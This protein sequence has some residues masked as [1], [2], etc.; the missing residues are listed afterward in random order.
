MVNKK[1]VYSVV[2]A[3]LAVWFAKPYLDDLRENVGI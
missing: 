2:A 3:L 1:T